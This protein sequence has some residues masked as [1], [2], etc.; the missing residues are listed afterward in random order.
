MTYARF[1]WKRREGENTPTLLR[2]WEKSGRASGVF[3]TVFALV[4]QILKIKRENNT[5]PLFLIIY[6]NLGRGES[7]RR[8]KLLYGHEGQIE[9]VIL[10]PHENIVIRMPAKAALVMNI[11]NQR[12][13]IY[14]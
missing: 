7:R 5:P 10:H 1:Y 2:R 12:Q 14:T 13:E 9:A 6:D 3:G 8:E 11:R 4:N